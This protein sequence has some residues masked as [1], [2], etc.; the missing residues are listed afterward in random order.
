M[1]VG[2]W[3]WLTHESAQPDFAWIKW[4]QKQHFPF[5]SFGF[6][7][8]RG[9]LSNGAKEKGET[10]N[11]W[12]AKKKNGNYDWLSWVDLVAIFQIGSDFTFWKIRTWLHIMHNV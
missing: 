4:P 1:D 3:D 11:V 7:N 8:W 10:N 2:F 12:K 6:V 5:W 9:Q